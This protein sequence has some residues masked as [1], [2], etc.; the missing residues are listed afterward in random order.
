MPPPASLDA[1]GDSV[2]RI[3]S[4]RKKNESQIKQIQLK[5]AT[6]SLLYYFSDSIQSKQ[7]SIANVCNVAVP[8]L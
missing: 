4:L 6:Y 3:K 8:L 1:S 2:S 7:T 5:P